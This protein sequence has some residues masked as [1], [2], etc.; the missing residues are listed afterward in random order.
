MY[1]VLAVLIK[2]PGGVPTLSEVARLLE[3]RRYADAHAFA[4]RFAPDGRVWR[5]FA[6]PELP[7]FSCAEV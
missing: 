4:K 6:V 7:G 5:L 1:E 2:A 3:E